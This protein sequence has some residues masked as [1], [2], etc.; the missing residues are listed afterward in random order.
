MYTTLVVRP[1]ACTV[2]HL[3]ATQADR[4][5]LNRQQNIAC[6][7]LGMD[8]LAL[9]TLHERALNYSVKKYEN[10]ESDSHNVLHPL[11]CNKLIHTKRYK[12]HTFRTE[13]FRKFF[14]NFVLIYMNSLF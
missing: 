1:Y 11:I 7:I 3:G 2:G 12:L 9:E 5:S 4:D 8:K 14:F 6:K 10:I 13:R